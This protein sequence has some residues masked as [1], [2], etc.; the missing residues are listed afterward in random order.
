MD[1]LAIFSLTPPSLEHHFAR[2]IDSLAGV[3]ILITKFRTLSGSLCARTASGVG[4]GG[5]GRQ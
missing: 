4:P 5:H 1:L 3:D 2:D